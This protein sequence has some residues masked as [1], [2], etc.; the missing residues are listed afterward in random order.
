MEVIKVMNRELYYCKYWKHIFWKEYEICV[1]DIIYSE[2]AKMAQIHIIIMKEG[3]VV[4]TISDL[5][6]EDCENHI[7]TII[8]D[9]FSNDAW[10]AEKDVIKIWYYNINDTPVEKSNIPL[11]MAIT[12][13]S[14]VKSDILIEKF[15]IIREKVY[16]C[17]YCYLSNV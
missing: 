6:L 16:D 8:R 3:Q 10:F 15:N 11:R 13:T 12:F 7:R 9:A 2:R 5:K 14:H 1:S 4:R 17:L